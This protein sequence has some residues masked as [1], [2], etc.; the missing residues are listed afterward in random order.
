M[1][2][3]AKVTFGD[4]AA[5]PVRRALAAIGRLVLAYRVFPD[6]APDR[7][8]DERVDLAGYLQ[9]VVESFGRRVAAQDDQ[10]SGTTVGLGLPGHLPGRA[11]RLQALHLPQ[12]GLDLALTCVQPG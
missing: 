2:D 7:E 10:V 5:R 8:A 11:D 9:P 6:A 12:C 1:G 3:E 4:R